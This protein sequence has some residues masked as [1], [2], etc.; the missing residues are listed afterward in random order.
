MMSFL[1]SLMAQMV[2][3]LPTMP[4]TRVQS[5]GQEDPLEKKMS[6]LAWKISWT[7]EPGRLWSMGLQRV[8]HDWASSLFLSFQWGHFIYNTVRFFFTFWGPS[9]DLTLSIFLK[10]FLHLCFPL[11][12]VSPY[13]STNKVLFRILVSPP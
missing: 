9:W 6:T 4:E 13:V 1:V 10:I 3:C 12:D 5:L 7:E 11:C 2:K 8:G